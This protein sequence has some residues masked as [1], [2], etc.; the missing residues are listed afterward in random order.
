MSCQTCSSELPPNLFKQSF[1]TPC[2]STPICPSCIN[3]NPRL[4]EYIPC[5]R[6]GDPRTSELKGGAS[7]SR[8]GGSSGSRNDHGLARDIVENNGD[9]VVFEIGDCDDDDEE[10]DDDAD[11]PPG[12]EDINSQQYNDPNRNRQNIRDSTINEDSSESALDALKEPTDTLPPDN[13]IST[14]AVIPAADE[15]KYET[16]EVT[17]EIQRSDTLLSISRRY[18]TDP[19]DL[20]SLNNLPYTALST[21]PRI[22]HTR[23]T[24]II[25]RRQIPSSKIPSQPATSSSPFQEE[26]EEREKSKQFKR[27]QLLTK[28]TDLGIANTYLNLSELEESLGDDPL[29][30]GSGETING[31]KKK[32]FAN[33]ENREQRALESFFEDDEWE[34]EHGGSLSKLRIN[35]KQST[36]QGK[37]KG[38]GSSW[39]ISSAGGMKVQ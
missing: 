22:L 4:K 31:H 16:V 6:C 14:P 21:H 11:A 33:K 35:V 32:Q 18:A 17:H 5:L 23:K 15:G 13:S 26:N 27:F 2:C 7:I 12:Y 1:I 19:H 25:S 9:E 10:E 8:P 28:N 38:G 34:K 20:L 39:N 36:G 29:E 24:L 37:G 3:R 30:S